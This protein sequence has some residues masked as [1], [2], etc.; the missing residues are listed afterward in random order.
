MA[1]TAALLE[2]ARQD[3]ASQQPEAAQAKCLAV[4][5]THHHHPGALGLLGRALYAQ[6]RHEDAARVFNA[7]T[8]MEPTDCAH[9]QNLATAL[10]PLKQYDQAL[11]A[12][13]RA[14][15]LG[16]PSAAL[17]YN[18]GILQMDRCDYRAAYLALRDA[19]ALAP[20]DATTRWAFAQCCYD[21]LQLDEALE[22]LQDWQT[23]QGLTDELT[24]RISVLLVTLGAAE[25]ARPAIERL[26]RNPPP[27][28]PALFGLASILERLQRLDEARVL[29]EQL[30]RNDPSFAADPDKLLLSATLSGRAGHPE[31]AHRDLSLALQNQQEFV[32]RHHLLYPFAKLND[33]LGRYEDAY[34]AA[35]EA[36]RSQMAF[37][38][39]AMGEAS[40]QEPRMLS[41]TAQACAP[42]DVALW[43]DVGP[44]M[45]DSPIFIVGFPRSGTT[46]LEQALDA[47]PRLRSMDEQPFLMEAVTGVTE[48]GI[49]YPVELAKLTPAMLDE[50]RTQYWTRVR[51]RVALQARERLVDKYPLNMALLPLMRRLFPNS[52]VILA[53]RH[54]CDTLLSCFMQDFRSP[55]VALMCRDLASLA[56]AYSRFFEFWYSQ[57]ELLHPCSY[58]L[59]Y[60]R[61]AA[62]F[63]TEM[64]SVAAFL[65]LPWDEAML[66]PGDHA[67]SKG[68]ISTPSYSQVIQPITTRSVGRWSHYERHFAPLMPLLQPWIERWGYSLK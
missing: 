10:R 14:L 24:V 49:R 60:E 30:E 61:L 50:I 48:R 52:Q 17:L 55:G 1:D 37:L 44:S 36:H 67:R 28:G 8:L 42:N 32:R 2:L 19:V 7:L 39:A 5:D 18:L 13:E 34:A 16:K 20:T 68:F 45:Q 47:H 38:H 59:R 15:R 31:K 64:R 62:D 9:W 58:E 66:S 21:L 11:A 63:A 6:G 53:I 40:A 33:T 26:V 12:F 27:K 3:L 46:L 22:T 51:K 41:F 25:R 23:F 43:E 65:E 56:A 54:P 4:L 57:C 35:A 29:L